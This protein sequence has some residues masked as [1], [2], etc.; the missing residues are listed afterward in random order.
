M[1]GT[2]FNFTSHTRDSTC[3]RRIKRLA[4]SCMLQWKLLCPA[5]PPHQPHG[6]HL[7]FPPA[8][9][10]QSGQ[11]ISSLMGRCQAALIFRLTLCSWLSLPLT[12]W[13]SILVLVHL[14]LCGVVWP[15][16][17]WKNPVLSETPYSSLTGS[18]IPCL[19]TTSC[20]PAPFGLCAPLLADQFSALF[21]STSS[22]PA[23]PP[24]TV[25][26]PGTVFTLFSNSTSYKNWEPWSFTWA[27]PVLTWCQPL[28]AVSCPTVILPCLIR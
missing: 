20:L 26:C 5:T 12:T 14:W 7:L 21:L 9:H 23:C 27:K 13:V 6:L 28:P 15:Q 19:S 24:V 11:Y 10:Q 2:H 18:T 3:G 25:S 8:P 17:G 22:Y 16:R 1:R 4:C